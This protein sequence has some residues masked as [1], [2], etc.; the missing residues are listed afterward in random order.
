[1]TAQVARSRTS[2]R[3]ASLLPWAA[4]ADTATGSGA[5]RASER[6]GERREP[7]RCDRCCSIWRKAWSRLT[8]DH[9]TAVFLQGWTCDSDCANAAVGARAMQGGLWAMGNGGGLLVAIGAPGG[10]GTHGR[11]GGSKVRPC[12]RGIGSS[13]RAAAGCSCSHRRPW[14]PREMMVRTAGALR[15]PVACLATS[16]AVT[17]PPSPTQRPGSTV[18]GGRKADSVVSKA[19]LSVGDTCTAARRS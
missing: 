19:S 2:V 9:A 8:A 10:W 3:A 4:G 13:P 16:P 11:W 1:M 17:S 15:R 18:K 14:D 12:S 5:A 6:S 7:V